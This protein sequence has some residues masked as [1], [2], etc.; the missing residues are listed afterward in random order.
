MTSTWILEAIKSVNLAIRPHILNIIESIGC[1]DQ[2]L[3]SA[4]GNYYGDIYE[5]HLEWAKNSRMN[6]SRHGDS[7]PDGY[8]EYMMPIMRNKL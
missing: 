1:S 4:I 6:Q 7:I 2:T 3:M 8:L 5:T